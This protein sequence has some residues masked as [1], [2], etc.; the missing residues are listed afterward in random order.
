VVFKPAAGADAD[1]KFTAEH[2]CAQGTA[3]TKA[4]DCGDVAAISAKAELTCHYT[5][6]KAGLQM[7]EEDYKK[8]T[9]KF[10]IQFKSFANDLF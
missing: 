1:T 5:M 9:G 3:P 4:V 7:L 2:S 6:G 8:W 10:D